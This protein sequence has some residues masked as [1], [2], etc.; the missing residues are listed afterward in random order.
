M[1]DLDRHFREAN[2]AA[3]LK[4]GDNT[5]ELTAQP[6]DLLLEL[7]AV[8]IEGQFTVF[9]D[10]EGHWAIHEPRTLKVG[11]WKDQ[12]YPFY[13]HAVVYEM[14]FGVD[15]LSG[16][17]RYTVRLSD[18]SGVSASLSVNGSHVGLFG[19][20]N[21]NELE[22]GSF[23]QT[24]ENVALIRVCGSF[25]N[26]FGP[27]HH[28]DRPRKTVWPSF[29]KQSPYYGPAVGFEYD[30]VEQGYLQDFVVIQRTFVKDS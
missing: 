22:I 20:G 17:N 5:I 21:V 13:G 26:L 8:Y 28:P 30:L 18:W 16:D 10:E 19:T 14:L 7:E 15:E 4:Y 12:G 2:I 27:F 25:K 6:F 1:P 24:G 11:S 23:L 9:P 3:L 29:W